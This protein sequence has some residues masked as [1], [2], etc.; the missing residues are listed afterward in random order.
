MTEHPKSKS[1]WGCY[2]SDG[3]PCTEGGVWLAQKEQRDGSQKRW[4]T[5]CQLRRAIF[6]T[7]TLSC[8]LSFVLVSA[9]IKRAD[10]DAIFISKSLV[11]MAITFSENA[12]PRYPCIPTTNS[13]GLTIPQ[14]GSFAFQICEDWKLTDS[15]ALPIFFFVGLWSRL[16]SQNSGSRLRS[17]EYIVDLTW[18]QMKSRWQP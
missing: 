18:I 4:P 6:C 5:T 1:M 13:S 11:I 10:A 3:S 12:F 2:H 16:P 15:Q 7:V 9:Q 17:V 8:E 14:K